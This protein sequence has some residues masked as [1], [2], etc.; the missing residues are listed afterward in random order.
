MN[1]TVPHMDKI[2]TDQFK[3]IYRFPGESIQSKSQVYN[4]LLSLISHMYELLQMV[5][6]LCSEKKIKWDDCWK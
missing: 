3:A 2:T 4:N 5:D 6:S 1:H